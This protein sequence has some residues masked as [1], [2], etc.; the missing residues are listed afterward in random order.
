MQSWNSVSIL[1]NDGSVLYKYS[2]VTRVHFMEMPTWESGSLSLSLTD[3]LET[4]PQHGRVYISMESIVSLVEWRFRSTPCGRRER[5]REKEVIEIQSAATTSPVSEAAAA[6]AANSSWT[7]PK[8]HHN[9]QTEDDWYPFRWT[10]T[11]KPRIGGPMDSCVLLYRKSLACHPHHLLLHPGFV[12]SVKHGYYVFWTPSSSTG[13][14]H[15]HSNSNSSSSIRFCSSWTFC[16]RLVGGLDYGK[17]WIHDM[18]MVGALTE[19]IL[20]VHGSGSTAV[21]FSCFSLEKR[22]VDSTTLGKEAFAPDLCPLHISDPT[23]LVSCL[24]CGCKV[25]TIFSLSRENAFYG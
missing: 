13:L 18:A 15:G 12:V 3:C 20:V 4:V 22:C 6:A 1:R 11:Q 7:K 8:T 16:S 2:T 21:L 19:R 14:H 10:W 24:V 25:G 9:E 23:R 5:E 17:R